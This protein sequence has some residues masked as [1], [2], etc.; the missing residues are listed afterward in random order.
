MTSVNLSEVGAFPSVDAS[1]NF[2]VRFGVYLPGVRTQ[3]G[4]Q[5]RVRIIHVEDRFNPEI[6]TQ[7]A[8]LDFSGGALDLWSKAVPLGSREGVYVYR[9][10]L[11]R[12]Y[13]R[14]EL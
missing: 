8:D 11:L 12:D 13:R 3:D 6:G 2:T 1:G 14:C 5:V 10:Q 7:D 4:F 9:Y